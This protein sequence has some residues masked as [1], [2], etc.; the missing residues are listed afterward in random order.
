MR[1]ILITCA[2]PYA[3][4]PI[5]IGHM[6]EHIQADIWVRYHR[7]VGDKVVFLCADDAH[8]TPIMVSAKKRGIP[9]ETLIA[10]IQ[11]DHI[12]DFRDFGVV[13]DTYHSTHSDENRRLAEAIY[14]LAK[15]K[16]HIDE[17]IVQNFYCISCEMSLPDRMVRGICPNCDAEDQYGDSCE[18]CGLAY[19][20]HTLKSPRCSECG[21]PPA[22]KDSNHHFFKLSNFVEPLK[23]WL[24]GP[25]LK[26]PAKKKLMEWFD[27]GLKDW[28]ISRDAPYFGFLIPGTTDKYFYVWLDAPIGYLATT[29]KFCKDKNGQFDE[30]W[31]HS[32]EWSVHHFIGKDIL[33]FHGLFWPAMLTAA[34]LRLPT[35][36]HVHGFLTV[37]GEKMSKSRGTFI[38]AREYLDHLNPS[39]LRYYFATKL[40]SGIDDID[41]NLEDFVLKVNA[42]I[43]N[44]Y[45]NIASRVGKLLGRSFSSQLT[46]IDPDATAM[47]QTLRDAA[48]ELAILYDET[49]TAKAMKMIMALTDTV[50]RYIEAQAPWLLEKTD[51]P[52]CGQVCTTAL[53][54]MAILSIYLKP[55]IPEM[56]AGVE[57]FLAIPPLSWTDIH[58]VIENHPISEYTHLA[59]RLTLQEVEAI[60][61]S[62]EQPTST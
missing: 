43:V 3:N 60:K 24:N 23:A 48:P 16:G 35:R 2:L 29:E 7:L 52:K 53:N 54:A 21:T 26:A 45:I 8:G 51:L 22:L 56:V 40:T 10:E 18:K 6:V 44:K 4:G 55:V 38:S 42:D 31:R 46:Q 5:H 50:N 30:F 32:T 1:K 34:E 20:V 17:K 11:A 12:R 19:A 14:T 41:F 28:D 58:R 27:S 57:A 33:Y 15:S 47:L 49:E 61:G 9:P 39:Y 13:V 59:K 36:L 25:H 37:N 62:V